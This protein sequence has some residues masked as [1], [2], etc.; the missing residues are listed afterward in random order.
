M[1]DNVAACMS[2]SV[3]S[4]HTEDAC[5]QAG[6]AICLAQGECI[7]LRM[8]AA[9]CI[10]QAQAELRRLEQAVTADTPALKTTQR[11][12]VLKCR[13]E[14]IELE[15]ALTHAK[16][17]HTYCD[18]AVT[19]LENKGIAVRMRAKEVSRG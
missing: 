2:M 14:Y 10:A 11:E 3:R 4:L 13:S 8:Q 5:T 16:A 17:V 19:L 18:S 7:D 1:S 12:R 6:D 9:A 15:S